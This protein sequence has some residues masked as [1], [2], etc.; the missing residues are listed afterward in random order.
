MDSYFEYISCLTEN[1]LLISTYYATLYNK[2]VN[3]EIIIKIFLFSVLSSFFT[4]WSTYNIPF[5]YH[6][7]AVTLFIVFLIS[8]LDR[9]HFFL[10]IFRTVLLIFTS[11]ICFE[12]FLIITIKPFLDAPLSEF[13]YFV[14]ILA[15]FLI[16]IFTHVYNQKF[17]L[18]D[19]I[20]NLSLV[21]TYLLSCLFILEVL[22][23]TINS[24]MNKQE[25]YIIIYE[26]LLLT[27]FLGFVIIICIN[28]KKIVNLEKVKSKYVLQQEHVHNLESLISIV[29]KE[30]HDFANHINTV[31][32]ICLLNKPNS[33]DRIQAY[34]SKI[35]SDLKVGY[36]I[37]DTGNDYLD[38]LLA[39]KSNVAFEKDINFEVSIEVS[40]DV[41]DIDDTDLISIVSNIVDNGLEAL[42]ST[43]ME[44]NKVISIATYIEDDI[45]HLSIANNGPVID[46]ETKKNI[47][48][49]GF[50]TKTYKKSDHGYGLYIVKQLVEKYRGTIDVLS[51]E[52]ETEFMIK[53]EL[54]E[55]K[56]GQIRSILDKAY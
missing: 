46:D 56:L 24:I 3:I 27:L 35:G 8:I 50:S 28:F 41:L 15:K 29:R 6:T 33:V 26:I 51:N 1:V 14:S 45:Y 13:Y 34:L 52:F 25:N 40:I 32:A 36:Q 18:A 38:G 37:N 11:Y 20:K 21:D 53:F 12:I 55:E 39:V 43:N 4:F 49:R 44:D 22:L 2:K 10:P 19:F 5:G 9:K 17:K 31:Y 48:Q 54:K 23:V 42:L 7:F 30:K 47:F 16:L